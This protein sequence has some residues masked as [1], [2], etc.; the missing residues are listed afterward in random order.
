MEG[1]GYFSVSL[2]NSDFM[3]KEDESR[4]VAHLRENPDDLSQWL[5]YSMFLLQEKRYDDA[6][7]AGKEMAVR[8]ATQTGLHPLMLESA[9]STSAFV[10]GFS[11]LLKALS[12][13]TPHL[14]ICGKSSGMYAE[15][16]RRILSDFQKSLK[17]NA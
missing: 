6:I 2:N 5:K 15:M 10:I 13:A 4:V 12:D 16:S 11:I 1:R 17:I 14:E 3:Q 8:T 7:V 9:V